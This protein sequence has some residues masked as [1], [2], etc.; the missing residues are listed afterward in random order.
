MIANQGD[1]PAPGIASRIV[2]VVLGIV[3]GAVYGSVGTVAHP[4][5]VTIGSIVFPY[6]LVV[7]LVGVLALFIGFRLVVGGRLAAVG[8]AVGVVGIVSLF[9]LESAGGSILIREGL[10]GVVWLVGPALLGAL[11]ISWPSLPTRTR[12]LEA[13]DVKESHT[14]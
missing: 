10:T 12:R 2:T 8:A 3:V 5:T 1:G 13:P 7:A 11:V 4:V 6:G 14:P 9:S